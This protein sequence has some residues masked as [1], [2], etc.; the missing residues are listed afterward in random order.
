MTKEKIQL[1]KE[2]IEE[3]K[4]GKML[5]VVDDKDREN[6]GDFIISAEKATS[7]DVNFMEGVIDSFEVMSLLVNIEQEY[8]VRISSTELLEKNNRTIAGLIKLI[9]SKEN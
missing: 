6:E 3:F 8:N 4:N 7:E 1:I 9:G 2:A 5:I